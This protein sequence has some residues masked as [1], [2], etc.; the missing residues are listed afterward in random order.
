MA[1][2]TEG[3]D[4]VNIETVTIARLGNTTTKKIEAKDNEFLKIENIIVNVYTN[5]GV[6]F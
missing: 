5:N 4:A 2:Q 6:I 1:R 3:V